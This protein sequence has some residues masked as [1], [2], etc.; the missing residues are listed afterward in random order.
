MAVNRVMNKIKK[1]LIRFS[2]IVL[3][4][5]II[6][7]GSF[8][9]FQERFIFHPDTLDK[10]HIYR[11]NQDFEE[12][13]IDTEDGLKLN[14]LLF[15]AREP[16]GLIFYLHGNAG[17]LDSWGTI[18]PL[19][20]D[21][22]YDVF[23]LDYRGFGKSEGSIGSQ[24]QLFSDIQMAYNRMKILYNEDNIIVL[25]YSIG[26]CAAT[27]LASE[28]KPYMLILQAPYYSLTGIIRSI[29]PVIPRFLIKYKLETYSY[30]QECK[31]PIV[32]F[33]GDND[34][35][36]DYSNS[37]WLKELLKPEDSFITLT[38]EG[39]NNITDNTYYRKTLTRLLSQ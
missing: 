24:E 36:I 17:S 18:A 31:M 21:L 8:Y 13:Y 4:L 34:R 23:I 15:K 7:C 19:Y 27:W 6:L 38:G 10:N 39:H 1:I 3:S 35:V 29:C 14:G 32:I 25:G 22:G 2:L 28:N 11:F 5:Y 37:L 9:F 16:K 26:T 30:I 12:I 20:T 33:H